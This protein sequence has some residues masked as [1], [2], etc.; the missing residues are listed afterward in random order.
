MQVGIPALTLNGDVSQYSK[1]V[2]SD[3]KSRNADIMQF[4][5]NK[6]PKWNEATQTH[7]LNFHG[8]V[9]VPSVKNFQLIM[10][11]GGED[12]ENYIVMQFGRI[13][14]DTFTM[15]V[16]YPLKPIEAFAFALSTFDAYDSA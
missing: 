7:C 8:R 1:D 11:G 5:R 4:L 15:D 10:E 2:L 9:T 3:I 12:R 14:E 13:G 16:R 6:S